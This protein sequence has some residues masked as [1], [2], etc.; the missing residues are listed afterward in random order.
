[1]TRIH[2]RSGN[3]ASDVSTA[4]E[5]I[6]ALVQQQ[7]I[8]YDCRVIYLQPTSPLRTVE[9]IKLAM[10]HA[11][12]FENEVLFSATEDFTEYWIT[13]LQG[14]SQ[15]ISEIVHP[16]SIVRNSQTRKPIYRENGNFYIIPSQ[17]IQHIKS[18]T[19]LKMTPF[20]T[21]K[22][23]DYDIDDIIDFKNAEILFK[24]RSK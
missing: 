5:L 19:D 8:P 17:K 11:Y 10:E 20:I 6:Q 2:E 23:E 12:D 7:E 4:E 22:E 16:K 14:E 15:R 3:L 21:P 13:T 18:L 1:L 9:T 24:S